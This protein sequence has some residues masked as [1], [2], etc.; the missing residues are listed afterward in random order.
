MKRALL[1]ASLTI[2]TILLILLI[3]DE[4]V[5]REEILD[6]VVEDANVVLIVIDTLRADHLGVYGYSHPTSPFLDEQAR[7]S[8]I[9]DRAM[10]QSNWT[11]TSIGSLFTSLYPHD[12][13]AFRSK[14]S[15][16]TELTT[17]AE[18]LRAH[19]YRTVALQT[20]PY[21]KE[22]F[23]FDQGFD[24][25][26]F[27][28][29]ASAATVVD[30]F[31]AD[32]DLT[33]PDK[34]FIYVH[35]MDPHLPYRAPKEHVRSFVTGYQGPLDPWV[36]GNLATVH[37]LREESSEYSEADRNHIIALY[38]AEI[39]YVDRQIERLFGELE[40]SIA[41][42]NTI[43]ILVSDHGEELWDHGGF[44]HGHTMYNELLRVPLIVSHPRIEP[45]RVG[46]LVR[47]VDLYPTLLHWLGIEIPSGL[48]GVDLSRIILPD[49]EQGGPLPGFSEASMYGT[50]QKAV[51]LG[52]YKLVLSVELGES[53]LYNLDVDPTET[54]PLVNRSVREGLTRMLADHAFLSPI[55]IEGAQAGDL[56]EETVQELKALGYLQ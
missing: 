39:Q 8:I 48:R 22:Q 53:E 11:K 30:R 23:H 55:E 21:L 51:Q 31:L 47:I 16:S 45:V 33:E 41:M 1:V 4:C 34:F 26:L 50:E 46:Q 18:V 43:V 14:D 27:R 44:E 9:F 49:G 40:R 24:E 36:Y 7:R 29:G 2:P 54:S 5:S 13:E 19:G 37:E 15:L 42:E 52:P 56:D 3:H 32:I 10:S 20:N 17:L 35:F 38:D 6:V 25:Y 12:H 28:N